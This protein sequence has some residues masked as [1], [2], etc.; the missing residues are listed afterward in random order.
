VR[1]QLL[2]MQLPPPPANLMIKP[3]ELS[4]TL[5]TRQ[6]FTQHSIDPA[7]TTCHHLMDPIGLGFEDFDGAG[8]FRA[9]ENG[10]PIDDSGE[11]QDSDVEG[12]FHGVGELAS[13]LASSDQVRACVATRWFRYGYGRGETSADACSLSAIQSQ[14]AAGGFKIRD[15]LIALTRT[16]AFRYRQVTQPAGGP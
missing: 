9:L 13:K 11:V 16:D 14:F 3:P 8:A 7:C 1:E 15:L 10:Q 5:S 12:T 2:C 4:A 6:R